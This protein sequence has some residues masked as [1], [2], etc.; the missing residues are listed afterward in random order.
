MSEWGMWLMLAGSLVVLELF[1]GTFYLLMVALGLVAGAL[2]ALSGGAM[3]LQFLAAALVGVLATLSL[4][5]SKFGKSARV[6][7]AHDPNVNLDIGQAVAVAEW[8]DHPGVQPVARVNYRGAMWDV[9]L[10]PGNLPRPGT[11]AILE[12]RGSRLIVGAAAQQV[13]INASSDNN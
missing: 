6:D 11:F 8:T 1:T 5:R 2:V 10:A 3:W 7:A 4:R 13:S 12:I 9:E